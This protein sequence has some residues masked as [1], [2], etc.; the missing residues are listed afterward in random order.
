MPG[1]GGIRQVLIPMGRSLVRNASAPDY[2]SHPRLVLAV[3]APPGFDSRH[4][5][6]LLKDRL[7]IGYMESEQLLEVI[8]YNEAAGR[9][10][11]QLVENY[12]PDT[13]PK[14]SYANRQLCIACHQNAAPIFSRQQWD[15]TNANPAIDKRLGQQGANRYGIPVGAGVDIPFA[16]DAATN[17]ANYFTYYQLMWQKACHSLPGGTD[18]NELADIR[19]RAALLRASLQFLLTGGL[20]FDTGAVSYRNDFRQYIKANAVRRWPDG[21]LVPDADIPNRNP[22]LSRSPASNVIS[23]AFDPLV[24]RAPLEWLDAGSDRALFLLVKGLA[25][26]FAEPDRRRLDQHLF[27]AAMAQQLLEQQTLSCDLKEK[28]WTGQGRRFGFN[29]HAP[30]T[31]GAGPVAT[32]R[33]RFTLDQDKVSQARMHH[34]SLVD[35]GELRNLSMQQITGGAERGAMRFRINNGM[36]HARLAD[37]NALGE[38]VL[39]WQA[40]MTEASSVTARLSVLS[41]FTLVDEAL[42]KLV[43]Q[44]S[45]KQTDALSDK[46][47]RRA[48]IM[49][50]LFRELDT[51][52]TLEWCCID[53]MTAPAVSRETIQ[54]REIADLKPF[55]QYCATCHASAS[56]FPANFLYGDETRVRAQISHCAERIYYRL[57]M[58][59]K[60]P[61]ERGKSPMPPALVLDVMGQDEAGWANSIPFRTL[62]G[63]VTSLLQQEGVEPDVAK[64]ELLGFDQLRSCMP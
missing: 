59:H 37:G 49:P 18:N 26:F 4:A 28:T 57:S 7:Y 20:H 36:L 40:G 42:R 9:F 44:A 47:F 2:F 10:E 13:Q 17:R 27:K 53:D 58:A 14:V 25:E 50:A 33:G 45:D 46:P 29:C 5:G 48:A 15:E 63:H 64:Y 23:E 54:Y 60:Q 31:S 56:P 32:L 43:Q 51:G 30:A 39:K 52:K 12:G 3:D 1:E 24:I 22:L 35:G 8:S 21:L 62:K 16:I 34:L 19:C 55:Y 11:F 6:L 41:D 38:L 61:D